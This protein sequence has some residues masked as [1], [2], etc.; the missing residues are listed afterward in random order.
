MPGLI[1]AD[2]V[3]QVKVGGDSRNLFHLVGSAVVKFDTDKVNSPIDKKKSELNILQSVQNDRL[4]MSINRS[5]V[6]D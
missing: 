4:I 1:I 3:A 2:I 5:R 6:K